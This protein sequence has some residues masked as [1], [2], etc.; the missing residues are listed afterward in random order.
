MMLP[1]CLS[2]CLSVCLSPAFS[3]VVRGSFSPNAFRSSSTGRASGIVS[4][5][6]TINKNVYLCVSNVHALSLSLSSS[7]WK[8]VQRSV[9]YAMQCLERRIFS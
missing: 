4:N 7:N 2:V 8:P 1:I 6:Y 9:L 5:I 3:N